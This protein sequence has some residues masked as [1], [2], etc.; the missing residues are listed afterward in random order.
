MM[1]VY[2]LAELNEIIACDNVNSPVQNYF[3]IETYYVDF[4]VALVILLLYIA[5]LLYLYCHLIPKLKKAVSESG[6]QTAMTA[7][8]RQMKLMPLLRS[9]VLIHCGLALTSKLI[10][11]LAPMYP[12]YGARLTAYGGM[13][14]T[15][16]VF[17]NLMMLLMTNK[18]LR[19][20]C[21]NLLRCKPA[22]RQ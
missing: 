17:V 10:L 8:K 7:L 11:A 14:V 20:A 21:I 5:L 22:D 18:D 3:Q 13:L 1:A 16:D 4:I 12:K 19:D 2:S 9:L 6:E 15:V